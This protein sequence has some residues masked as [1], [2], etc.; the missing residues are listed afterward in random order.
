MN[1]KKLIKKI[2]LLYVSLILCTT[3]Y[4]LIVN[5]IVSYSIY[6]NNYNCNVAVNITVVFFTFYLSGFIVTIFYM[7]RDYR[8]KEKFLREVSHF[9][10]M[11]F[12]GT[13]QNKFYFEDYPDLSEAY[14]S[15][16]ELTENLKEK[17]AHAEEERSQLNATLESIPDALIILDN[18]NVVIYANDKANSLFDRRGDIKSKPLIEV[19]RSPELLG[20][21]EKVKKFDKSDHDEIFLEYPSERYLQVRMSPFY[22]QNDLRGCVILLHDITEV[23]KLESVRKDF[24][25]NVSHE[26]KTPV[27]AIKGFAETLLNGALDDREYAVKFLSTIKFQSERLDR[28][29]DDLMTISK[30]ESGVTKINKTSVKLNELIDN[31]IEILF[32]KANEK[33]LYLKKSTGN[34][35]IFIEADRD[36][37]I[38]VLLNV[39][40]NA[41]KFTQ[42][43]GIEIGYFSDEIKRV[44]YVKDTGSGIPK[45]CLSRIGERFFRVDPSR[46]RELGGTG[47]GMAIVKHIV[48]AHNWE[49][50][51][52]SDEGRGTTVK[53]FVG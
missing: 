25:A 7:V 5:Q 46:S 11:I 14:Y 34:E 42:K 43:G 28:L 49:M 45:R 13:F 20:M 18:K 52:D 2:A 37:L 38:Q 16:N 50:K 23:K 17:F 35:D 47:L 22:K 44:L 48:K 29:V 36:R 3:L 15:L 24:V 6:N 31:V 26:I 53:L 12:K 9:S 1:L 10:K 51:I 39:V 8:K 41:I 33:D 32:N 21:L 4:Y 19:V 27:T 40:D 30:I